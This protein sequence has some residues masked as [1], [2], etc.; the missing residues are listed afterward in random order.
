MRIRKDL[1]SKLVDGIGSAG[2]MFV[3]LL[4]LFFLKRPFSQIL[5]RPGLLAYEVILLALSVIYLDRAL[6]PRFSGTR[7]AWNGIIGGVILWPVIYLALELGKQVYSGLTT[8][9]LFL[10]VGLIIGAL[11]R[12]VPQIGLRFYTQT[13]LMNFFLYL[14]KMGVEIWTPRLGF[15]AEIWRIIGFLSIPAAVITAGWMFYYSEKRIQRIWFG[16]WVWFFLMLMAT[17]F[18]GEPIYTFA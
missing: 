10:M 11:W 7:Q 6:M 4:L 16:V 3:L 17:V 5:G 12:R 18:L 13:F 15:L 8:A 9:L 1:G 2:I 14:I